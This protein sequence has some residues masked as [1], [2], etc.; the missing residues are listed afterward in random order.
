MSLRGAGRGPVQSNLAPMKTKTY[1]FLPRGCL[2][3]RREQHRR[4]HIAGIDDFEVAEATYRVGG[5][6]LASGTRITLRQAILWCMIAGNTPARCLMFLKRAS[7]SRPCGEILHAAHASVSSPQERR[8][9][10]RQAHHGIWGTGAS[11]RHLRRDRT[12]N[13]AQYPRRLYRVS[14]STSL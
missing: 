10:C 13:E 14:A 3:Q 9:H 4:A 8:C 12:R 1:L 2:G 11:S 7:A 6:T 5:R